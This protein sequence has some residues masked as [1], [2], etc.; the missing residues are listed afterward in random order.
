[1]KFTQEEFDR[2]RPMKGWCI[3]KAE[4]KNQIKR[5]KLDIVIEGFKQDE[6]K[7]TP[8][9]GWIEK[10]KEHPTGL[11]VWYDYLASMNSLGT[12]DYS[13]RVCYEVGED[14]YLQLLEEEIYA[15]KDDTG[16]YSV[17]GYYIVRQRLE[18][19]TSI[20]IK[21]E[22]FKKNSK[23]ADIIYTPKTPS[24]LQLCGIPSKKI[25]WHILQSGD[26]VHTKREWGVRL[27]S[28]LY[29]DLGEDLFI[30]QEDKIVGIYGK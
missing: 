7:Y 1:M 9:T 22:S 16:V 12:A 14:V 8:R 21:P 3:V 10:S 26:V 5:G 29:S 20:I 4:Y 23:I 27:E 19:D 2:V 13:S 6:H 15:L 17:S 30:L 25:G 24:E 28:E 11:Y 18:C